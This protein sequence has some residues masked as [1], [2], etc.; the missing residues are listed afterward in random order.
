MEPA[1][2]LVVVLT[3]G[4]SALLVWFEVNSRRNEARLKRELELSHQAERDREVTAEA[5][6]NE[7]KAA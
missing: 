2:I 6:D 1:T 3:I 7:R 5:E 4:V